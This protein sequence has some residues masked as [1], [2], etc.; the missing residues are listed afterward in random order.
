MKKY[1]LNP[2]VKC[3]IVKNEG[4]CISS[5]DIQ[6][7]I[8]EDN[9][10][11][12]IEIINLWK[13]EYSYE[14]V[15]KKINIKFYVSK[16]FFEEIFVF[17]INNN[18]IKEHLSI[19]NQISKFQFEKYSRQITSL[20]TINN[21][22]YIDAVDMQNKIFNSKVCV[23]GAG[24]TGSHLLITLASIGVGNLVIVDFDN[25]ELS[26]TS[27]QILYD[28]EDIG[29][30][31]LDV[32][33]DK[34]YKYNSEIKISTYNIKVETIEDFNFLS[35]EEGVDLLV[36]CADTPRGIIQKLTNTASKIYNIPWFYFGPYH[37]SQ[38]VIGPYIHPNKVD[39][40]DNLLFDDTDILVNSKINEINNNFKSA[41]CEPYNAFSAQ[42]ASIEIFKILTGYIKPS[43]IDRRYYIDTDRWNLEFISYE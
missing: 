7:V 38:I 13:T 14:E 34:L 15:F 35:K 3:F 20:Y 33:K 10:D 28:E 9:V 37:H 41:I 40:Y 2:S 24:G 12:I 6:P 31:K 4:L 30:N 25:I 8:I 39:I 26:N 42:F 43:I 32:A 21:V 1:I 11:E 19:D 27:R 29:K 18:I 22:S 5:T 36:L 16:N 23:I 17:L